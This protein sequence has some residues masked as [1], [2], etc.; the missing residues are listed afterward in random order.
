M[1]N[2]SYEYTSTVADSDAVE[3]YDEKLVSATIFTPESQI[4]YCTSCGEEISSKNKIVK[5]SGSKNYVY[6]AATGM[7]VLTVV[8]TDAETKTTYY[9][10]AVE[11]TKKQTASGKVTVLTYSDGKYTDANTLSANVAV[12]LDDSS[13]GGNVRALKVQVASDAYF[14]ITDG[15]KAGTYK[16][17]KNSSSTYNATSTFTSDET[18]TVTFVENHNHRYNT[19]VLASSAKDSDKAENV[20]FDPNFKVMTYLNGFNYIV[21][22]TTRKKHYLECTDPDCGL[23]YF[24]VEHATEEAGTPCSVCGYDADSEEF[25]S[26][27][28]EAGSNLYLNTDLAR[29]KAV[30]EITKAYKQ[31]KDKIDAGDTKQAQ[32]QAVVDLAKSLFCNEEG[33]ESDAYKAVVALKDCAILSF[34]SYT[35]G[36]DSAQDLIDELKEALDALYT[37]ANITVGSD[38][39]TKYTTTFKDALAKIDN[40]ATGD[41]LYDAVEK[42]ETEIAKEKKESMTFFVKP[43]TILPL[44]ENRS[45]TDFFGYTVNLAENTGWAVNDSTKILAEDGFKVV[46]DG[47]VLCIPSTCF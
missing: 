30:Y 46:K 9:I 44:T 39:D 2:D 6:N 15:A 40:D 10:D 13:L 17:I 12:S 18:A 36:D 34:G 5:V 4:A 25:V 32:A 22:G 19:A 41:A 11:E 26:V 29:E 21:E 23:K 43:S 20:Y 47:G 14:Y 38:S 42:V 31:V 37:A 28:I 35:D 24:P 7:W 33:K 3:Y 45:F 8:N 27:K 16:V 1:S